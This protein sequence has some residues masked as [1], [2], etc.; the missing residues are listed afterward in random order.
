MIK[1]EF[2]INNKYLSKGYLHLI[3]QESEVVLRTTCFLMPTKFL[4]LT[5][6]KIKIFP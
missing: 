1:V 2:K 6:D 3:E 4:I 5:P